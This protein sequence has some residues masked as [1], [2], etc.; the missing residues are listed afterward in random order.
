MNDTERILRHH[1]GPHTAGIQP[2][3]PFWK[4]VHHSTFFWVGAFLMLLAMT[5]FVMTDG[6]ALR[7]RS[8]AQAPVQGVPR[9]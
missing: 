5:V 3:R 2:H 4:R 6:F 1:G 8:Q 9:P 7:P